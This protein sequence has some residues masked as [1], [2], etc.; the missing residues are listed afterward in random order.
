MLAVPPPSSWASMLPDVVRPIRA[1]VKGI[2]SRA[3]RTLWIRV[4]SEKASLSTTTT[5]GVVV[6]P[7]EAVEA[8]EAVGSA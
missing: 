7:P 1:R 2:G 5:L 4:G 6:D 8:P 3:R